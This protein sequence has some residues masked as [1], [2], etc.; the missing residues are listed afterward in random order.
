MMKSKPIKTLGDL[1]HHQQVLQM[2][3]EQEAAK[4][5]GSWVHLK[6]NYKTMFWAGVNPFKNNGILNSALDLIK[7]GLLPVIAEVA[8]GSIKGQP[9]NA[10]VVGSAVK[11][12]VA[13]LGIKWLRKWLDSKQEEDVSENEPPAES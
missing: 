9:L 10:K 1:R 7:P 4:L 2:Q 11:Y 12:T 8:K 3:V 5:N 6:A 13:S